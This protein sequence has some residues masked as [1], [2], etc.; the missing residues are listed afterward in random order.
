[1][2]AR[3]PACGRAIEKISHCRLCGAGRWKCETLQPAPGGSGTRAK[4]ECISGRNPP[5]AIG[6][7]N[8]PPEMAYLIDRD[9]TL[10]SPARRGRVGRFLGNARKSVVEGKR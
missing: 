10:F 3:S 4:P 5:L 6:S 8:T 9:G 2:E 1:M 7:S